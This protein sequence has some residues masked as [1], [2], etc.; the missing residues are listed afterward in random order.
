MAVFYTKLHNRLLRPLMTARQ[1]PAPPEL[2]DA[3]RVIDRQVS[4]YAIRARL[5]KAA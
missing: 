5:G 4:D 2:R 1:P 3:L